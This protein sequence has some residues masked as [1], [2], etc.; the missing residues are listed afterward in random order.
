MSGTLLRSNPI[1]K[2]IY[3]KIQDYDNMACQ[4]F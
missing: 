1:G 3:N 4:V 2:S